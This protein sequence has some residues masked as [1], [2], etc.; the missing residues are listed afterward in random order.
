MFWCFLRFLKTY[1]NIS[2]SYDRLTKS[3]IKSFAL[4]NSVNR[5]KTPFTVRIIHH[6]V[7]I[8]TY[9]SVGVNCND[10]L[11]TTWYLRDF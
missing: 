11:T 6:I 4:R 2:N 9:H 1:L 3:I 8:M 5:N 7:L 10:K